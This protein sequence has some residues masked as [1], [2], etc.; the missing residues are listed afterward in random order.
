VSITG[1]PVEDLAHRF[2]YHPPKSDMRRRQH[3]MV[4]ADCLSLAETLNEALPDGR[5]K[6]LAITKI[7]EAMFW[8]NAA[9]AR[10]PDEEATT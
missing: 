4:R 1:R 2:N 5:E 9:L 10:Q 8:A 6:S 3:E 7:E